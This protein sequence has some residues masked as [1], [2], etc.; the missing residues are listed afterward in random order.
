MSGLAAVTNNVHATDHLSDGEESDDL[1]G[2][3][4]GEGDFLAAG[5]A[6]TGQNALRRGDVG[7]LEV[8]RVASS[9]DQGLEVGL[10]CGHVA[11]EEIR[12][13]IVGGK[14]STGSGGL[15]EE[16]CSGHGKPACRARGRPSSS[17]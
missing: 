12:K 2:G 6:D 16:S 10:E 14:Y 13:C 15:T 4:T 3:D 8:G 17:R 11:R 5:A 9:V 1:R 7:S